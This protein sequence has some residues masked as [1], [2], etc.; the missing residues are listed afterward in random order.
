M[1]YRRKQ[2][3]YHLTFD[4]GPLQGFEMRTRV[5]GLEQVEAITGMVNIDLSSGRPTNED[6]AKV[7]TFCEAMAFCITEWN[8]EG[9]DG[10]PVPCTRMNLLSQDI[11]FL[12]PL[13]MGWLDVLNSADLI[14]QDA[15]PVSEESPVEVDAVDEEWLAGLPMRFG[16]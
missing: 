2:R 6:V 16:T 8:L 4:R 5:P 7:R 10:E 14:P 13:A 15:E 3:T 11:E 1:G 9:E 12:L